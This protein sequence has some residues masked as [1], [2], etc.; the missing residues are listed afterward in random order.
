MEYSHGARITPLYH[1]ISPLER[2]IQSFEKKAFTYHSNAEKIP[3]NETSAERLKREKDLSD[4]FEHL[5]QER[6]RISTLAQIQQRLEDYRKQAE[7]M[8]RKE[9]RDEKHHPARKLSNNLRAAGRP[10]PSKNHVAHHIVMG[11]GRTQGM[12]DARLLMY[13]YK[14]RI[15][16]PDNGSWMPRDIKDKGHW[17]MPNC[18]A[19]AEIHG[20]NYETWVFALTQTAMNEKTFRATLT[21][22]RNLLRDG[23]QPKQ[24]TQ[25]KKSDWDGLQI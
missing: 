22:I 18:P 24:I 14:I 16:D 6:L 23:R 1:E 4:A 9:L 5:K 12:A 20:H 8:T 11:K 13:L 10:R 2:A 7:T 21:R 25:A 17:S 15:N 19:H 3:V